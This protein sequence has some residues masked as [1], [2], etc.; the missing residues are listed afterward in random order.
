MYYFN[1][2]MYV[3]M[4]YYFNLNMYVFMYYL[5]LNMYVVML[6]LFFAFFKYLFLS[7]SQAASSWAKLSTNQQLL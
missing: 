6:I 4:M 3:F 2:N 1:L 7:L 5:N